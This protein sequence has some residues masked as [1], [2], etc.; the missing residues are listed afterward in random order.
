MSTYYH[1]LDPF[2]SS[3]RMESNPRHDKITL[4][5]KGANLGTLVVDN[6]QGRELLAMLFTKKEV[7]HQVS[8][9]NHTTRLT[10]GTELPPNMQLLSEYGELTTKGAL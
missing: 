6:G 5:A 2:F 9:P 7:A 1:G 3:V 8:G 4:F 10:R